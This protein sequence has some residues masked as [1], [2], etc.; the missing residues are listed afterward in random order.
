MCVER[1]DSQINDENDPASAEFEL[2]LLSALQ[3]RAAPVGM[4]QRVLA[5]ARERR[6]ARHGRLWM[7]QRFAMACV[8]IAVVG[9]FAM[10]RQAEKRAEERQRGEAARAQ[11][12]LAMRITQRTLDRVGERVAGR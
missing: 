4:K 1:K 5:L 8:L 9:G 12:M 3:H 2:K 7:W 6:L 11:V 10:Y